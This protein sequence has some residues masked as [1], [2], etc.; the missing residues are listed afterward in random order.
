MLH[1][2]NSNIDN[3]SNDL[4]LSKDNKSFIF[5]NK[6]NISNNRIITKITNNKK[7]LS[8]KI[9]INN[10]NK[11]KNIKNSLSNY[12]KINV[13]GNNIAGR[14][15]SINHFIKSS[16]NSTVIN[17]SKTASHSKT[18][19]SSL[20]TSSPRNKDDIP[21][22]KIKKCNNNIEKYRILSHKK[23]V[24]DSLDD[25]EII[26]DAIVDNY[27]INPDDKILLTFDGIVFI[28]AFWCILYKPLK[29]ALNNC[30]VKNDITSLNLGNIS[31]ILIDLLFI[32]D[33]IINFFRAYYN[34]DEQLV[35]KNEKIILNYLKGYF[36][37]DFISAIPYYSIIKLSA[38]K[39]NYKLNVSLTCSKYY[40]HEINDIYQV[41]ELLKIIKLIKYFTDNNIIINLLINAL[42]QF[43]FFESWSFL[44]YNVFISLLILHL[45]ACTHIF[46]SSTAFP[47]WIIYKNLNES[48]FISVYLSSI[49][50]LITTVTSVGYGDIIGNSF[51]EIIFQ[52]ILLLIG[53]I[54]YS[55]LISSLSNYVKENNQQ[56][57]IF[58]QKVSILNEIKLEH[59]IMTK[60]LYD[61]IHL[62]LEYINLRQKK[63]KSSLI[64]CLP[65]SVKKTLLY[66]MYKP[67]ID[68]FIFFKNF[69]NSEFVNRVISKLKPVLAVKNDLL[70]EQGEIIEDTIFVKQGR[71]SL[72]VKIDSDH[73]E[74]SIEKLLNEEYFFGIENNEL[75]QKNAMGGIINMTSN[76]KESFINKKN[77]YNL[78]S[79]NAA[80]NNIKKAKSIITNIK[81][82]TEIQKRPNLNINY[83]HLRILDI[84]KNEHFGALLMF[85]NKRSPLSLRVKTKKAELFFLKKIDAIEI[86]TSYPNIWKRVNKKSFHNL[87]QIKITM[88]KIIKHFCETY[89]INF[90]FSSK[91]Y[92]L[93]KKDLKKFNQN[94]QKLN[95]LPNQLLDP[96]RASVDVRNADQ[97]KMFQHFPKQTQI[98]ATKTN[99]EKNIEKLIPE[100]FERN[101]I[102]FTLKDTKNDNN[103]GLENTNKINNNNEQ[104]NTSSSSEDPMDFSVSMIK[105]KKKESILGYG[106]PVY[107]RENKDNNN[108]NL[109]GSSRSYGKSIFENENNISKSLNNINKNNE[110]N[111]NSN[112]RI[113]RY[114]EEETNNLIK[115]FGTPYYPEDINDEVYPGEIFDIISP[116]ANNILEQE[117]T[118]VNNL[119][120]SYDTNKNNMQKI[121]SKSIAPP[122]FD[123]NNR[124]N[125]FTI[126][127]NYIMN[128]VINNI[129]TKK[130]ANKL[131][132]F[133]FDININNDKNKQKRKLKLN[134]E[135]K[136]R[137][138]LSIFKNSFEISTNNIINNNLKKT[139]NNNVNNVNNVNNNIKI[140]SI[141]P[142][143][144]RNNSCV[145]ITKKIDVNKK[146]DKYSIS[147]SYDISSDLNSYSD[148]NEDYFYEAQSK[149]LN[150]IDVIN[151][152]KSMLKGDEKN[153]DNDNNNDNNNDSNEKLQI[154]KNIIIKINAKYENLNIITKGEYLKSK[155]L[156][157]CIK[158]FLIKK[159]LK[160]KNDNKYTQ[161]TITLQKMCGN[162]DEN[163]QKK[164][165][166]QKKKTYQ[167]RRSIKKQIILKKQTIQNN[168]AIRKKSTIVKKP[169]SK[170]YQSIQT[171]IQTPKSPTRSKN[172]KFNSTNRL[173]KNKTLVRNKI[174]EKYSCNIIKD[175]VKREKLRKTELKSLFN[176]HMISELDDKKEKNTLI[177]KKNNGSVKDI[178]EI[179]CHSLPKRRKT[180][181]NEDDFFLDYV[182]RNIRDDNAVLNNPGQFYNGFFIDIMKRVNEGKIKQKDEEKENE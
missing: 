17:R 115:F 127:N 108:N 177:K 76:Y 1:Q 11:N 179:S 106:H 88:K 34:F 85:L 97:L 180:K 18:K 154:R 69:K 148:N 16:F 164:Q 103:D 141:S 123:I 153:S 89:G 78:Y 99:V 33:L 126:N 128:N 52:I 8:K 50:F 131:C 49:Y 7:N 48:P 156:Q 56:N 145:N 12:Y 113:I 63:D 102:N 37:I 100:K 41:I 66:E 82:E 144:R 81:G 165:L 45:T 146:N 137:F 51:N 122:L 169:I 116:K 65:H 168:L 29:L 150:S 4:L 87:K 98:V 104:K 24:Y 75:Y 162:F 110:N 58:N 9:S 139:I 3:S 83:I 135:K 143:H 80:D 90:D 72:E 158:K 28:L 40:N 94:L 64:D 19:S 114:G 163:A 124:S 133:H 172:R 140:D 119:L 25:E 129:N 181:K 14:R 95:I 20:T 67:I 93:K 55:W 22:I 138:D 173:M 54:A 136:I 86:S 6:H 101:N 39:N 142:K 91:I 105:I 130:N 178:S 60:D 174:P 47:N 77:L 68:N 5:H 31:N 155:N 170:K 176:K 132:I 74:K 26:E 151:T 21:K 42:N 79:G 2:L 70:L 147:S 96:R 157:K 84:R 57:E 120:L 175:T 111:I 44:L 149:N 13:I 134:T 23:L 182:N 32:I 30:D 121:K 171:N 27:Y 36:I 53:I 152:P 112:K 167:K 107:I 73:P 15:S 62:H 43:T 159:I 46:V 92:N 61:R 35:K 161:K 10:L 160:H 118:S 71:L 109:E 38:Y 125:N 59:P 166:I 117:Y